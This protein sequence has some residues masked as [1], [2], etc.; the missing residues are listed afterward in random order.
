MTLDTENAGGVIQWVADT[1][2]RVRA[3]VATTPDGGK[4][5]LV[6]DEET[7][8]WRSLVRWSSED[9]GRA[10]SIAR[11]GKTLFLVGSHSANAQQLIAINVETGSERVL[12]QD[13]AY[14]VADVLVHPVSRAP[15]AVAF[16]RERIEWEALDD[17]AAERFAVLRRE[18]AGQLAVVSRDTA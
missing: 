11:D 16:H 9:E 1:Q 14:D 10:V 4:Q 6:R 5:V 8:P 12:A 3:A 15:Q 13:E 18:I 17:A 2:L 7:A